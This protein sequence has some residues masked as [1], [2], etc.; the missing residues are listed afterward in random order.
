MIIPMTSM[1][2][3][4]HQGNNKMN[5]SWFGRLM[6][7]KIVGLNNLYRMLLQSALSALTTFALLI[8]LSSK[9]FLFQY[10]RR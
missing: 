6:H 8:S 3:F 1:I 7:V 5:V 10:Q 4:N 9:A 2:R